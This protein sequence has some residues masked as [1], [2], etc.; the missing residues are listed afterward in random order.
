MFLKCNSVKVPMKQKFLLHYVKELFKLLW[1]FFYIFVLLCFVDE[2]F[3]FECFVLPTNYVTLCI[4]SQQKSDY[5]VVF[6]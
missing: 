5:K 2:I 6:L 3:R 4:M 1:M